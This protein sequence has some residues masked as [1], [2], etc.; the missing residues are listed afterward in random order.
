MS[1]VRSFSEGGPEGEYLYTIQNKKKVRIGG[2][3]P[4][5][6]HATAMSKAVSEAVGEGSVAEYKKWLSANNDLFTLDTESKGLLDYEEAGLPRGDLWL[7]QFPAFMTGITPE[8]W[9]D[10]YAASKKLNVPWDASNEERRAVA[11]KKTDDLK[12]RM[13]DLSILDQFKLSGLSAAHQGLQG[14]AGTALD[15]GFPAYRKKRY[16]NYQDWRGN[17]DSIWDSPR[18]KKRAN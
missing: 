10:H 5:P 4:S 18:K 2:P 1:H 14:L 6:E 7:S 9:F 12:S 11:V 3:Y 8:S 17:L 15:L 16:P 13:G